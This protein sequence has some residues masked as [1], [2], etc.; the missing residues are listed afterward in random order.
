MQ[1]AHD[2]G[3]GWLKELMAAAQP[4]VGSFDRLA[5]A[6]LGSSSWPGDQPIKERSLAAILSKLDR[7]AD[8]PWLADRPAVQAALAEAL[9]CP[10]ADVHSGA[11]PPQRSDHGRRM[12][13]EDAR[14]ARALDLLEEPLCPGIPEEVLSPARWS[15]TWWVA[16]S[17]SGRTLV[18]RWLAARG[19]AAF[20]S[21]PDWRSAL[22]AVPRTGA[23]FVELWGDEAGEL[24]AGDGAPDRLC[25]ASGTTP[26]P[27]A[28][29]WQIVHSPKPE[30]FLEALA[31]WLAARLPADS[32]FEPGRAVEWIRRGPLADG[33]VDNLGTALGLL[34]ALDELE[35]HDPRNKR[36]SDIA[37]ALVRSRLD[38]AA[39]RGA[40]NATWLRRSALDVLVSMGRQLLTESDRPWDAPRSYD[41]WLELVPSEHRRGPDLEWLRLSL[42]QLG[43]KLR[44]SDIEQ[45]ARQFPPGAFR[46]VRALQGASILAPGSDPDSFVIRPRWLGR[47][48]M[49]EAAAGLAQSSPFE[50]GEALL[51]RPAA[52]AVAACVLARMVSDD[53]VLTEAL[54]LGADDSPAF[55]AALEMLV[56]AA[57]FA[58]L[59]GADLTLEDLEVL[60][61]EQARLLF[62]CGSEPPRPR[63]DFPMEL[64]DRAP[65]L[66]QGVWLLGALA[67]TEQLPP[68]SG[69]RHPLLRPWLERRP[70]AGLRAVL[71]VIAR[72]LEPEAARVAFEL[73]AAILIDRLRNVVGSV[74]QDGGGAHRLELPGILL[75]EIEHGV[76]EWSNVRLL[77]ADA[78]LFDVLPRLA[79]RRGLPVAEL[80]HAIWS[81]WSN[82]GYP[83]SVLFE[84]ASPAAPLLFAHAPPEPLAQL[85]PA[86][87]PEDL[88]AASAHFADEQWQA[89]V[90]AVASGALAG[91]ALAG[92]FAI[93]G[94]E[95]VEEL[96]GI[97][98]AELSDAE[99]LAALWA[100]LPAVTAAAL[101]ARL[102]LDPRRA[103]TLIDAAPFEHTGAVVDAL[104][105]RLLSTTSTELSAPALDHVRRW[106][107]A[108]IAA[109]APDWRDAYAVL[110]EIERRLQPLIR[111]RYQ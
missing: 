56:R 102:E 81:A 108:R 77:E 72:S 105:R 6:T 51:R 53:G 9:G 69:A 62:D 23:A 5:R 7:G 25:V 80:P 95:H 16:P 63:V 2:Q 48:I 100:R 13:L 41:G 57:G 68:R 19:L 96:L 52:P 111:A 34:G 24:L 50:W 110:A 74:A 44:A 46:I 10:V 4:P 83:R 47:T 64:V 40:T 12:R 31:A 42:E 22:P 87:E 38:A 86:L 35:I 66:A 28:R 89:F 75:D 11:D 88:A 1:L 32:A 70:P 106:L 85:L 82:A 60:W 27:T 21:A 39:E 92:V 84:A 26:P 99:G 20:V 67:L 33:L 37:L 101:R 55:V 93:I 54:E 17:G 18:G 3:V 109:R 29:P 73:P 43:G 97:G 30:Q 107:H 91:K 71:D 90:R 76:L 15:R 104:R 98:A 45:T 65:A 103:R 36:A 8:L 58:L 94:R 49:V 78:A 79:E 59:S 61:N 14:F